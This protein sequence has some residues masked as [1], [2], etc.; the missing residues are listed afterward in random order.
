MDEK[1]EVVSE[2]KKNSKMILE[3][4]IIAAGILVMLLI[5]G[6]NVIGRFISGISLSFSEELVVYI[7]AATS[8]IGAS[9]ACARGANMGL[10]AITDLLPQKAQIVF[11]ILSTLGSV[12]LFALLFYQGVVTVQSMIEYGQKTPILRIPT[13]IFEIFYSI[14][15]AMYI[16]R[17]IQLAVKKIKELRV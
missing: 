11:V 7:F 12:L 5:A 15:A 13:W 8:I 17:A 10:S 1:K 2:T 16:F 14:G 3:E 6:A 4:Y 9:A